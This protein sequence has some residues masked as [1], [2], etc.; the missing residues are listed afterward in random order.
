MA[1]YDDY[2]NQNNL[3][4]RPSEMMSNVND[5]LGANRA[6]LPMDVDSLG[7][8]M[9]KPT[10]GE[11]EPDIGDGDK[12][13]G[14]GDFTI[15]TPWFA[16]PGEQGP[17]ENIYGQKGDLMGDFVGKLSSLN[18]GQQKLMLQFIGIEAGDMKEGISPSE[19]AT[20]FGIDSQ[21]SN[22]FQGFP[23]MLKFEGEIE[24]VFAGGEQSM[25]YEQKA[26]QQAQIQ[27]GGQFQGGMGFSGFGRGKG[28]ANALN[29]RNL[30]DTLAQRRSSIE[31]S[32]ANK[33]GQ[34]ISGL[35]N[36]INAGFAI[37]GDLLNMNTDAGSQDRI[38]PDT[39]EIV[40][41]GGDDRLSNRDTT[42]TTRRT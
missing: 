13:D 38:D 7:S 30:M 35:N 31:E 10:F 37:A 21:Y 26:A 1:I 19:W 17:G 32:T 4:S 18:P 24:N 3:Y 20:L 2:L 6:S 5:Y 27:Q 16:Q 28:M 12:D 25:S 23:S 34:L 15:D 42:R 9:G 8:M 29:R 14:S 11:D 40:T 39:G 41:Y 22:R 36:R 33:Y